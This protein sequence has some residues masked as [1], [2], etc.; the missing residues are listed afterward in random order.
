L[1]GEVTK[2]ELIAKR[3]Q[4][5]LEILYRSEDRQAGYAVILD[6]LMEYGYDC[7]E[8][9]VRMDCKHLVDRGM[10]MKVKNG[11]A[12][13][14]KGEDS[15]YTQDPPADDSIKVGYLKQ[16]AILKLLHDHDMRAYRAETRGMSSKDIAS[17]EGI[18]SVDTVRDIL[19]EMAGEGLVKR[20]GSRWVLGPGFPRPVPVDGKTARRIYEHLNNVAALV[21]LPPELAVLKSKLAPLFIVPDRYMWREKLLKLVERVAVHG[22]GV[23]ENNDILQVLT[24]V[25]KAIYNCRAIDGEYRGRKVRLHPLGAVYHWEKGQW[26]VIARNP[27]QRAIMT[28]RLSRFSAVQVGNETFERPEGFDL[29]DYLEKRWGISSDRETD[30]TVRFS[31]TAWHRTA[32]EKLQADVSRR[33]CRLENCEDGTI[34]LHDKVAGLSEF[35][36]WL[37]S[38]GDAAEVL[39]PGHL[40]KM[41]AR[42]GSRMLQRYGIGGEQCE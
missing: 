25:E 19:Q 32:L 12:I 5:I 27:R 39:Q 8:R 15:L 33:N 28:F 23:R 22:S 16:M 18:G 30:V 21:S 42:T 7:S 17:R 11:A 26:Y 37:R 3:R 34:I 4:R 1:S 36:T 40:Q 38:Y 14:P 6:K 24:L 9:T 29:K 20:E 13:T 41:L 35:E 10:A 2:R 31:E